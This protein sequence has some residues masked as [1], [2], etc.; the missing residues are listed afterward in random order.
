MGT[1][2][3][4]P[5]PKMVSLF[6]R[7]EHNMIKRRFFLIFLSLSTLLNAGC[8]SE[9][10][11]IQVKWEDKKLSN[12]LR[13][14]LVEDHTVPLISYQTWVSVGSVHEVD[15][16]TGLAHFFEHLMFK[17]TEKNP[18][19]KFFE[20]LEN[21]GAEVNAATSRDTTHFYENFSPALLDKVIEMEADRFQ[22]LVINEER[23][24]TEKMV[25]LEER[26][27]RIDSDPSAKMQEALWTTV[28]KL[29]PYQ[30]PV[31]GWPDDVMRFTVEDL[32]NFF[33]TYYIPSRTSLIIVGDF[34]SSDVFE[35]LKK[36]YG[37]WK[38]G[39]KPKIKL[40]SEPEQTGERRWTLNE[41]VASEQV[42]IGFPV[43][44][45]HEDDSFALDLMSG[46]L[47]SGVSS[48]AHQKIVEKEQTALS[49]SGSAYTPLYPGLF[50]IH[51]VMKSGISAQK[52]ETSIEA[53]IDEVKKNSVTQ[54][55]LDRVRKQLLVGFLDGIRTPYGLGQW[56]GTVT[57]IF[58][59]P[60]RFIKDFQKYGKI[61]PSDIQRVTKKYFEPNKRSV[62]TLLPKVNI[63]KRH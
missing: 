34:K 2:V 37:S 17:G 28:F 30:H 15:G 6:M 4:V 25:V 43:S 12:G 62:V 40:D 57:S 36:A 52:V 1:P 63:T 51:A 7:L 27:L 20:L 13:I 8:R 38:P 14:I 44:A 32:Q 56:I 61:T 46:I 42:L 24:N 3:D 9:F 53:L 59:D 16:K 29:H 22:N 18:G 10:E 45:A 5:D 33:H 58:G 48:R 26:R 21:Q 11:G 60:R 54:A 41:H 35:K 49:V 23:M 50:S 47:F 55:E 19:R 31:S 39:V